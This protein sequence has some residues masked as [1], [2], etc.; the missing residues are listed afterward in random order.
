MPQQYPKKSFTYMIGMAQ[1]VLA[2]ELPD[3]DLFAQ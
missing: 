1:N 2:V 3:F